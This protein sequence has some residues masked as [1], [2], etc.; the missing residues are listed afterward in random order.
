MILKLMVNNFKPFVVKLAMGSHNS[1][2]KEYTH[3]IPNTEKDNSPTI[4]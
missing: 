3:I 1:K 2:T 4:L